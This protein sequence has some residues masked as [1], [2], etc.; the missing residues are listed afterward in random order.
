MNAVG[1]IIPGASSQLKNSQK[2]PAVTTSAKVGT[3][4]HG[5]IVGRGV[6]S[7]AILL[8]LHVNRLLSAGF[9]KESES[10]L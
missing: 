2:H 6:V 9:Y 10:L 3:H 5:T 7:P 1:N 8:D 4:L